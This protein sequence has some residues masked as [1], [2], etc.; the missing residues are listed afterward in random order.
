MVYSSPQVTTS[1]KT[2]DG[3]DTKEENSNGNKIQDGA[4]CG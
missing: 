1:T 3:G 4:K 2:Y